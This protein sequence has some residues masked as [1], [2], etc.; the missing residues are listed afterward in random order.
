MDLQLKSGRRDGHPP[1]AKT[2]PEVVD[3]TIDIPVN[4]CPDC[5]VD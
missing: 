5:N 1:A 3:R 4:Q 2:I